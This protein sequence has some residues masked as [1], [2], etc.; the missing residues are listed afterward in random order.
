[1]RIRWGHNLFW[2]IH[3]GDYDFLAVDPIRLWCIYYTGSR[4]FHVRERVHLNVWAFREVGDV[5]RCNSNRRLVLLER[6]GFVEKES[7]SIQLD[8]LDAADFMYN[9]FVNPRFLPP[10]VYSYRVIRDIPDYF[11]YEDF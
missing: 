11:M 10:E 9:L 1:L 8:G 5:A 6:L 4:A 2:P 7:I 3:P